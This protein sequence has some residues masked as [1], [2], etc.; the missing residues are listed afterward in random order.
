LAARKVLA[1]L[2]QLPIEIVAADMELTRLAA[3]F[4]ALT[5]LPYPDC[6]AAALAKNRKGALATSDPDFSAVRHE[7]HLLRI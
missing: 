1:E 5:K 2:A 3:E 4:R 6:F 7:V